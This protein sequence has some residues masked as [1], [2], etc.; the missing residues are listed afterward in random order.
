[1]KQV[2]LSTLLLLCF[3]LA[4]GSLA[5]A[6][7]NCSTIDFGVGDRA[8]QVIRTSD[9]QTLFVGQTNAPGMGQNITVSKIDNM[10]G[11]TF[12]LSLDGVSFNEPSDDV[13]N[14]VVE[15]PDG[16]GYIVVGASES[17]GKSEVAMFRINLAGA[18]VWARTV[19]FGNGS[20]VAE[21]IISMANGDFAVVGTTSDLEKGLEML[22]FQIDGNGNV[23][24][25]VEAGGAGEDSGRRIVETPAGTLIAVGSRFR[26]QA[27][28]RRDIFVA[29][30]DGALTSLGSRL[31][32]GP[33]TEEIG[34]DLELDGP[35]ELIVL[36]NV[37]QNNGRTDIVVAKA[38]SP[39]T[40]AARR[41]IDGGR[42]SLFGSDIFRTNS[43]NLL[44]AGNVGETLP[45]ISSLT[46]AYFMRTNDTAT[47]LGALRYGIPGAN[48]DFS[49]FTNLPSGAQLL[50]GETPGTVG[51]D[52]FS[53]RTDLMGNACCGT[54]TVSVDSVYPIF[55]GNY[56]NAD[57]TPATRIDTL[58]DFPDGTP[59]RI[60]ISTPK[61]N[62]SA[63]VEPADTDFQLFP[64]PANS[65]VALHWEGDA[66]ALAQVQIFDLNGRVLLNR[67]VKGLHAQLDVSSLPNGLYTLRLRN[68]EKIH[69]KKLQI[70][71]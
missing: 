51:Q 41:I 62:A 64:N 48:E 4:N 49:S 61:M 8:N 10:G 43:D 59:S 36:A 13:G 34:M 6:Q 40:F 21:H 68:N 57:P 15:V 25:A 58:F 35:G 37:F 28:D 69:T 23:L 22:V 71:R 14:S 50:T 54:P 63:T 18:I 42:A 20:D 56:G 27:A 16:S 47:V 5:W 53:V 31:M 46:D 24:R 1:M 66:D 7:S 67:K 44:I 26:P 9:N 3:F 29:S 17:Q 70:Q 65:Q 2:K 32:S 52:I 11:V 12:S 38:L 55:S 39:S 19:D 30:F 33:G 45:S 60:C